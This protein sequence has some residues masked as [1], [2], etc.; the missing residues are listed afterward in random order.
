MAVET[1]DQDLLLDFEFTTGYNIQTFYDN[2]VFF[3]ENQYQDIVDFYNG[4][5]DQPNK[6]AFKNLDT[7]IKQGSEVIEV[8]NSNAD[9]LIEYDFWVLLENI[10][11]IRTSLNTIKNVAKY[12]RSS[13]K[14][15]SYS[16]DPSVNKSLTGGQTL[17]DFTRSTIGSDDFQNDWADVALNNNVREE[18]YNIE[19][20]NELKVQLANNN[21]FD[22]ESVL[23]T[24]NSAEDTYG[25]DINKKLT[26]VT[27]NGK[28]DL[29][30]LSP[31]DTLLQSAQILA[32]LRKGDTPAF[33]NDGIDRRLL[34]VSRNDFSFPVVFRQLYSTYRTD[35]SFGSVK[36]TGTNFNQDAVEI[37]FELETRAG[38]FINASTNL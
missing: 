11:E 31:Q 17:E 9:G 4:N 29:E 33:P 27:E 5:V 16:Q 28:D 14:I 19:G 36:V 15:G 2:Y 12:L 1:I 37:N 10:E 21:N 23:N 34:G 35:D 22:I 24:I 38:E 26:F 18:D 3:I 13:I 8:F 7:L 25:K 20:G 32:N 6:Q 30:T